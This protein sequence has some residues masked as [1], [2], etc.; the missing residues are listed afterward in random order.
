MKAGEDRRRFPRFDRILPP[1]ERGDSQ[2]SQPLLINMS[3][4]GI[5]L[6]LREP[7]TIGRL[8]KV[9]L[10][11]DGQEHALQV[12]LVWILEYLTGPDTDNAVRQ[13]GWLA[14]FAFASASAGAGGSALSWNIPPS[15][16]IAADLLQENGSS[17]LTAGEPERAAGLRLDSEAIAQLKAAAESLIPLVSRHVAD[18]HLAVTRER[19]ELSA[20]FRSLAELN[21]LREPGPGRR[22]IQANHAGPLPAPTQTTQN[23]ATGQIAGGQLILGRRPLLVTAL[24]LL[25][26]VLAWEYLPL[27]VQP[28]RAAIGPTVSTQR[29]ALPAWT[30]DLDPSSRN[31]WADIQARFGLTDATALSAVRILK[32]NDKYPPG[33]MYRDLTVHPVQISRAF[34]I[35]ADLGAAGQ[36]DLKA[37][38]RD[39][40]MKLVSGARLPDEPP[41]DPHSLLSREL[42]DNFVVL[43]VAEMLFRRQNDPPVKDLLSALWQG[44]PRKGSDQSTSIRA[45][46]GP[47]TRA[48]GDRGS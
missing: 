24:G 27:L 11:W 2:T 36:R 31:G 41:G 8:G 15:T 17:L 12:R 29:R 38:T 30:A 47:G 33:H 18:A 5:C 20:T 28:D 21:S 14:G 45:F 39:L 26:V 13:H 48:V 32:M 34:G 9:R 35:L 16:H 42:N 4:G 1:T 7:P 25:A 10:C 43:A 23:A 44:P 46:R 3:A 19:L 40:G 6:W 22:A 37:L